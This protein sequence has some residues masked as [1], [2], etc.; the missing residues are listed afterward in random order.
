MIMHELKW[1]INLFIFTC[2]L[3][4]QGTNSLQNVKIKGCDNKLIYSSL[5]SKLPANLHQ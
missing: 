1:G 3:F 5:A 4:L 2:N